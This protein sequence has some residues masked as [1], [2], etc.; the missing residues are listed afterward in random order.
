MTRSALSAVPCCGWAVCVCV[1]VCVPA[2]V[3]TKAMCV[4]FHNPDVQLVVTQL[5]VHIRTK[6]AQPN[7]GA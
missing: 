7:G 1:C 5:C 4:K 3:P 6:K 2:H